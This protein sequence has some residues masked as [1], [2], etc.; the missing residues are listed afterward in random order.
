M[1]QLIISDYGTYLGKR[2]ERVSVRYRD[3]DREKEEHPLMDLDQIVITS[4]GVSMSSDLIEA[5][6]ERGIE[7]AFLSFNGKPYAKLSSP[8]LTATVIS[9]REQLAAY[10]DERGLEIAKQFAAGKLKNQINL[11]RYFG[12]YRKKQAPKK[13]AEL[14]ERLTK[15]EGLI[16]EIQLVQ[17]PAC[18]GTQGGNEPPIDSARGTLLNLEGRGGALYW[19]CVQR[20]LPTGRF[21]TRNHQ[22]AADDVNALLNYGYGILYSQVWSALTLAGL[23]PFA[24]FLH[25]DRPG[26][27]SLVLDF[28]EEF[29]QPVVDRVVFAMINKRF[30]VEWEDSDSDTAKAA[31][32]SSK[33]NAETEIPTQRRLSQVTRRALADRVLAR[34]QETERF[35]RKAQKLCNIIQLQARHLAMHL[36]REREY[37]PFTAT[38]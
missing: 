36:R 17:S 25:V 4:R 37:H 15:I 23:E 22:G 12:K 31:H 35:E 27:P 13:Y 21:T 8:S 18:G 28:I 14:I 32:Q 19:E 11:V 2:S 1:E 33:P 26:K 38:W 34:L 10:H 30:K 24:G 7:I 20:L 16:D 29:R 5:C 3:K 9:R 6:T